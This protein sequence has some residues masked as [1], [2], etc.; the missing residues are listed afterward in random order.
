MTEPRFD[1]KVVDLNKH[2]LSEEN[3]EKRDEVYEAR[4]K[5]ELPYIQAR[6]HDILCV[7]FAKMTD[8]AVEALHGEGFEKGDYYVIASLI[9]AAHNGRTEEITTMQD[10]ML[11]R[12]IRI[13]VEDYMR[14][15]AM[16]KAEKEILG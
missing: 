7:E 10:A 13:L 8:E 15:S 12:K 16:A 1:P 2:L 14:A 11:G 4:R 9:S 3:R 6:A 5:K